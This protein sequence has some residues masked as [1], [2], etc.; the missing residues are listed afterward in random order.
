MVSVPSNRR[1]SVSGNRNGRRERLRACPRLGP[2]DEESNDKSASPRHAGAT[3]DPPHDRMKVVR[4]RD[5]SRRTCGP[6]HCCFASA[7]GA[8]LPSVQPESQCAWRSFPRSWQDARR[9]KPVLLSPR[10]G[11]A[12]HR[13]S[14]R[15]APQVRFR[16][17]SA[18]S[19]T[20]QSTKT[21]TLLLRCRFD[22]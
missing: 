16:R 3:I 1:S 2:M 17:H 9:E 6:M 14:L 20:S 13:T 5:T 11:I 8:W 18:R 22:G 12:A 21:R 19:L 10:C 7:N 15:H 4:F